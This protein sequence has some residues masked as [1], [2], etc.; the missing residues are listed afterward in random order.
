[1]IP[2]E[3]IA[4]G[5]PAARNFDTLARSV[6]DTGGQTAGV[7]FGV[8][9][10]SFT[11][12]TNS[13]STTVAHGLGTTPVS[14]VATSK[15]GSTFGQIPNCNTHTIGDTTF[16]LTGEVKTAFTGSVTVSWIAI[17]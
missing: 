7:R 4:D 6:L 10:L 12:S 17:G 2:L 8:A 14:I 16:G 3:K 11:A 13:A 5:S 9:T 15:N 1:M